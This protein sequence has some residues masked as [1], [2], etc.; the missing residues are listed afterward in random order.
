M[1]ASLISDLISERPAKDSIS[2]SIRL[3]SLC[4]EV[5]SIQMI[6]SKRNVGSYMISDWTHYF[7]RWS[8][9]NLTMHYSFRIISSI[10][11]ETIDTTMLIV[12]KSRCTTIIIISA[13][14][15]FLV[16]LALLVPLS[17]LFLLATVSLE[18]IKN[19]TKG[20]D[21]VRNGTSSYPKGRDETV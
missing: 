15:M 20:K 4:L 5:T 11:D 18:R 13:F 10:T 12:W 16:Y 8:T 21:M 3:M 2:P 1:V 6:T 19:K 17:V 14:V 9:L 7:I